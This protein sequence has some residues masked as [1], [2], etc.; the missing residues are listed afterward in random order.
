MPIDVFIDLSRAAIGFD[1]DAAL[2]R[3]ETPEAI[4]AIARRVTV[5]VE[6]QHDAEGAR[7]SDGWS[8]VATSPVEAC[9]DALAAAGEDGLPLLVL[10]GDVR[11]SAAAVGSMLEAVDADPMIGFASARLAGP[12]S[13]IARLDVSGDR[14]IDALPRRVLA[15]IPATYLVADAPGRC[16]LVKPFVTT[17]F[18]DVDVR[19]RS[20]AG[21]LWHY[22]S[23]VRRCGFRTT[24]CNRAVVDAPGQA[25][26]CPP[27]TITIRNLPE[28]D[29]VLLRELAPDIEKTVIRFGTASAAAG[30]TRLARAIPH[31]YGGR[32]SLLLDCRNIV[33]GMNGTT[34]AA[35]GICGGL[36]RLASDWDITL[37]A[38][39]DACA[40]HKLEASYPGWQIATTMP[41]RQF[42]VALRLSQPWHMQEMIDLHA[43]AAYN[44]YLFLDTIAWD[45]SYPAPVHIDGVWQFLADHA[46][47]LI[48]ISQYTRDR[49]RHRFRVR[50][51]MR[52]MVAY[53]SFDPADYVRANARH[54]PPAE[55]F[56]FVVGNDYDHKD[57]VPTV[58]LLAAAFPYEAIVALGPPRSITPRVRMLE[59]GKLSEAAM[60]RLYATARMVVF[61][62]FYEGFGFPVLTTL[63]YGG[64][65]VARRSALLDEIAARSVPRGRIVPF[66][67]RDELVEV[68]GQV[69]HGED[70]ATLPLG[71]AIDERGPLSWQEIGSNILAFLS[72]MAGD[73]SHS[74]FR[75]REHLLAQLI[76]A[77]MAL[78]DAGLK[79]PGVDP[80][81]P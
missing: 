70:V 61:P 65:L 11:P 13:G 41:A 51:G 42:T 23:R 15:E 44:T 28:A 77:P 34:V 8:V 5:A 1:V 12:D 66:E 10:L 72:E 76:A 20:V 39:K 80:N 26:P 79:R 64:T 38:S 68:I 56:I 53:L 31:A 21:A 22:M 59:S 27:S 75:T 58:E 49:F 74:R 37:L 62:S 36:H 48:F 47:G 35:L 60:H 4:G 7:V 16:L 78:T 17:E 54:A 71:T 32:P 29:R 3:L 25:R 63:A 67:R 6:F 40:F 33:S 81:R 52:E 46:D 50:A 43:A 69:L 18:R 45:V 30:E 73:L 19:F 55:E 14:E 9:R 2:R 24:I 57:I